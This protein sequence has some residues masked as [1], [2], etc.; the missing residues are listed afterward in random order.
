MDAKPHPVTSDGQVAENVQRFNEALPQATD[1]ETLLAY[2]RAWYYV[3]KVDMVGPSKFIGY[4]GMT[5][6][7][8]M[9]REDLNGTETE[10]V[11]KR[12]FEVL[13]VGTPE[14]KFVEQRVLDLAARFGKR[15]SRAARF[16]APPGWKVSSQ[17]LPGS[18]GHVGLGPSSEPLQAMNGHDE[19]H[20]IVEVFVRAYSTLR[21][22]EQAAVRNRIEAAG[23]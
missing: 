16:S 21:P 19:S 12:W 23:I 6:A 10:P 4:E 5:G 1:L 13:K 8:Y 18:S 14:Y 20:A 22:S 9:E 11:L 7:E 15:V 3:P 2:F 17:K